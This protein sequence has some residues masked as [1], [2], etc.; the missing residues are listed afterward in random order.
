MLVP[1]QI[2][3]IEDTTDTIVASLVQTYSNVYGLHKKPDLSMCT[4]L[5]DKLLQNLT[6]EHSGNIVRFGKIK[7][8]GSQVVAL[9]KTF[10]FM[11]N[12][13]TVGL[14]L[15]KLGRFLLSGYGR[16]D[17]KTGF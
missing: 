10:P 7:F 11:Y 8:L 14:I 4:A 5:A 9:V 12:F 15:T 17:R 6:A 3:T 16:M 1:I 13:T 2:A